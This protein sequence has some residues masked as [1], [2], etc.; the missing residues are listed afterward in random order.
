VRKEPEPGMF[1][2]GILLT[3][4]STIGHRRREKLGGQ[5]NGKVLTGKRISA[6]L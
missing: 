4:E 5:K 1:V 3:S 6:H 2:N